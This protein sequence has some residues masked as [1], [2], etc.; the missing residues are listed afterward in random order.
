MKQLIHKSFFK[1]NSQK[2]IERYL[3][4]VGI[5]KP[6]QLVPAHDKNHVYAVSGDDLPNFD[7]KDAVFKVTFRH[8][9]TFKGDPN[10]LK[11][12][13]TLKLI[14]FINDIGGIPEYVA[15]VLIKGGYDTV[16]KVRSAS[17][18]EL[19]ALDGIGKGRL[20]AIRKVV[21]GQAKAS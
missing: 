15:G 8:V 7:T 12:L 3:S 1:R 21:D 20:K 11:P 16:D 19:M 9:D 5:K 6:Y 2:G 4:T 10:F 17:D 18:E 13:T 14:E